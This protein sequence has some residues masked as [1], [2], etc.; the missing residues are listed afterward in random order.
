MLEITL[1]DLRKMGRRGGAT[2]RLYDGSIY[3]L[4]PHGA[5]YIF[6]RHSAFVGESKVQAHEKSFSDI[7]SVIRTIKIKDTVVARRNREGL[8]IYTGHGY[9]TLSSIKKHFHKVS[10]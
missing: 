1:E 6:K 5:K 9:K 3:S 7:Y 2:V 8:L 10:N 4:T